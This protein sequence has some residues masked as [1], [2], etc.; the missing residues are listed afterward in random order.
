MIVSDD[1][2]ENILVLG[3]RVRY[4]LYLGTL[5]QWTKIKLHSV[6]GTGIIESCEQGDG[7]H[8]AMYVPMTRKNIG[9]RMYAPGVQFDEH[10][11]LT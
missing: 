11:T 7:R 10:T 8:D 5:L 2:E 6:R 9:Y 3:E 4:I 1:H